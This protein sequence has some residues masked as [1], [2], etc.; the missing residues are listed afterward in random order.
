MFGG[1]SPSLSVPWVEDRNQRGLMQMHKDEAREVSW[2]RKSKCS[3]LTS[4]V[5]RD[6]KDRKQLSERYL[7]V[8]QARTPQYIISL[9]ILPTKPTRLFYDVN[10]PLPTCLS[11][12]LVTAFSARS[13]EIAIPPLRSTRNGLKR[14]E[15]RTS[16]FPATETAG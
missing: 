14:Q 12:V 3:S 11:H 15:R 1:V 9:P 4:T 7:N 2:F 10:T 8:K 5:Q 16:H 13:C 6:R